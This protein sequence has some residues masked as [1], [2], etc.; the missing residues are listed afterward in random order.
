[1]ASFSP[2]FGGLKKARDYLGKRLFMAAYEVSDARYWQR[3]GAPDDWR[4][5]NGVIEY[6]PHF[7]AV[8]DGAAPVYLLT[9]RAAS[10]RELSRVSLVIKVRKSGEIHRQA[11]SV[12]RLG[13]VPVRMAL[14]GIPLRPKGTTAQGQILGKVYIK[15]AEAVDSDGVDLAK[16]ARI[17]DIFTPVRMEFPNQRF[18]ER[19]GRYWNTDGIDLEMNNYRTRCYRRLVQSAGQLWRPLRGRRAAYAVMASRPGV[20]WAFWSRNLFDA[21]GLREAMAQQDNEHDSMP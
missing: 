14:D 21:K 3:D 13:A 16:E 10:G 12:D 5:L 9:F 7:T 17:T 20:Y 1:M 18:T 8:T 19:W 11:I 6:L 4:S 2:S 15:L